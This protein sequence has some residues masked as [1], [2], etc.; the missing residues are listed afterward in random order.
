MQ[1]QLNAF[2]QAL[3]R[4]DIEKSQWNM[5]FLLIV[6]NIATGYQR[7]FGLIAV[8]AHPCQAHYSTLEEVAYKLVLLEDG[9]VDWAYAF[10]QL[11]EALSLMSLSSEGHTSTITGSAP[12]GETHSHL[13]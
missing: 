10:I 1:S 8:W 4:G 5:A 9:N 2:S 11:H 6:P 12:S 3:V 7:V 13:H